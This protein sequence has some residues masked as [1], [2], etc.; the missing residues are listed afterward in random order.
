MPFVDPTIRFWIG[1]IVTVTI[2]V[3]SGTLVLT[4]AVPVEWIKPVTAWCGVISFIG[5]SVLTALNG[6]ATTATSRIAAA[7]VIPEVGKITTTKELA[8]ASPSPKVVNGVP[9]P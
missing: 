6:M 4:N 3:S 8:D 5:S 9:K 1:I 7:A 2:G